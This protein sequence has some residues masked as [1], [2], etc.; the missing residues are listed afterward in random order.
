[1]NNR[2]TITDNNRRQFSLSNFTSHLIEPSSEITGDENRRRARFLAGFTAILIPLSIIGLLASTV[3]QSDLSS[4]ELI[5]DGLFVVIVITIAVFILIYALAR[6]KY[7]NF[8]SAF[9]IAF[10]FLITIAA[11]V[12][13]PYERFTLLPFLILPAF[14][15]SLLLSTRYTFIVAI[16]S[17]LGGL[18]VPSFTPVLNI[19]DVTDIVIYNIMLSM[20]ISLSSYI[21]QQSLIQIENQSSALSKAL[22]ELQENKDLLEIRLNQR[23]SEELLKHEQT[24]AKLRESE[25]NELQTLQ[26]ALQKQQRLVQLKDR[27]MTTMSHEFRTPLA[28]ISSSTQLLERYWNNMNDEKRNERLFRIKSQIMHLTAMLDDLAFTIKAQANELDINLTSIDLDA[29]CKDLIVYMETSAGLKHNFVYTT[30]LLDNDFITDKKMLQYI[31]INLLTN[32]VKYSPE[33]EQIEF[34][35]LR[36]QQNIVIE[37][38]DKGIGIPHEDQASLF[39]PYFRASNVDDIQGIGVGLSIVKDCVDL[40]G[41]KVTV[42]SV[43]GESTTFRVFLPIKREV[44]NEEQS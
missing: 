5:Q 6:T 43:L 34:R 8:G 19:N 1:M 18:L 39:D 13:A 29:F 2:Q 24:E 4:E 33:G 15:G 11:T 23:L 22:D 12:I 7:Y 14:L 36:Q 3:V 31:V 27:F 10:L 28:V 32:A 17:G 41:G 30:K 37:V 42:E 35:I 16:A 20:L 25:K 21:R 26:E 9:I 38:G 40:L 44:V